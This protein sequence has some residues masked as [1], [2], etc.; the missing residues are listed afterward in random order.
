MDRVAEIKAMATG[1]KLPDLS[2]LPGFAEWRANPVT[3]ELLARVE[4]KL[5]ERVA[6][7][8]QRYADARR[9]L[10]EANQALAAFE[11][12]ERAAGRDDG[13]GDEVVHPRLPRVSV[14]G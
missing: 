9:E 11:R 7:A 1:T 5:L 13:A 3:V 4:A 8:R 10:D 6:R 2:E 14:R 12:E